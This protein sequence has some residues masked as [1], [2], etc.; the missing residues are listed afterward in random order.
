VRTLAAPTVAIT[1]SLC[2][3]DLDS[4][5]TISGTDTMRTGTHG[6]TLLYDGKADHGL[7]D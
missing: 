2:H 6:Q 1:K 7:M 5:R 3:Q 4:F